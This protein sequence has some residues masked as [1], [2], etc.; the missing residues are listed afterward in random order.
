MMRFTKDTSAPFSILKQPTVPWPSTLKPLPLIRT[1][2]RPLMEIVA[3]RVISAESSILAPLTSAV[4]RAASFDTVVGRSSV[5]T[6]VWVGTAVG[7]GDGVFV[8]RGVLVGRGVFVGREVGRSVG[9]E[10]GNS[11]GIVVG[12]G[13]ISSSIA[14]QVE[15]LALHAMAPQQRK[16][17]KVGQA[18][19][20]EVPLRSFGPL[21]AVQS[22]YPV[23]P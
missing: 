5:G 6:K 13:Q 9:R 8:G 7:K 19:H 22:K 12:F 3:V 11:V 17:V 15:A 20:D 23:P 16:G 4:L 10:V 18:M 14:E 1:P 21:Q 2:V